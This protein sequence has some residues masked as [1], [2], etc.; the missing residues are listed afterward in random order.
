MKNQSVL[1]FTIAGMAVG[2]LSLSVSAQNGKS[3]SAQNAKKPTNQ[4]EPE[5]RSSLNQRGV[6]KNQG[7]DPQG[8]VMGPAVYPDSFRTI[9]GLHNNIDNPEWGAAG[10]MLERKMEA[11]YWDGHDMPAGADRPDVRH[12]SNIVNA[13]DGL[14]KPNELDLSDYMWQWGQ[15]LDHDID[16]TPVSGGETFDIPVPMGDPWFDPGSTGTVT[17]PMDRSGY[18]HIEGVRQQFNNIT[19]YIDASNVYGSEEARALELRANDGTGKLKTSAGDLLPFNFNGFDNAPTG[20]D[21]S[22]FLGGDVRANEQVGLTSMHVLFMREHNRIAEQLAVANPGMSGDEIYERA[23]AFVGAE[24]QA[25]TFNEFLPRLLGENAIPAYSGY[26]PMVS[27]G[28]SNTFAT[29]AYRVGHTMLSSEIFRMD[30]YGNQSPEGHLDLA[31]AFFNPS[32][33]TTN[34]IDSLL[35]GLAAKRAQNVDS[36]VVDDVRNF[37]FGAPGSGGF[38]LCSLNMQRGRD[39]GLPS[40]N[41]I[42]VAYGL[43]AVTAFTEINADAEISGRLE[44]AYGSVDLIDPWI[45]FLSESHAPGAF[46][47]ETLMAVLGDQFARLRDSDRF[48]Y[49]S[50][51]PPE[52]VAEVE[53]MTLAE[54]IKANTGIGDELQA[55]VFVVQARCLAD[56]ADPAGDLDYLDIS[57]FVMAYNSGDLSVDFD[58]SGSVDFLDIS[59]F[60]NA[61]NTGCAE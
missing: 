20:A 22:L 59:I 50:Y 30:Q 7:V 3:G 10:T 41:E 60:L 29:A 39:H 21:S 19:S 9:D 26:D 27:A 58:D 55:D 56:L 53:A 8:A 11:K 54:I 57:A 45:G 46:V 49:E 42:R 37:L 43:P 23:R 2:I 25:I 5:R 35:R 14:D 17:I 52:L 18:A 51:L 28:I 34:G 44:T 61:Y 13:Q 1:A 15:F 40:Y 33:V 38:D 47:G 36:Y 4:L 24:M 16:E 6:R 48:W 32:E 31:S 12:I